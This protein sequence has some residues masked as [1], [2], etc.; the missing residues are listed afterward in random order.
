MAGI[1]AIAV[2]SV[3]AIVQAVALEWHLGGVAL[4]GSGAIV[5]TA[6]LLY[7]VVMRRLKGHLLQAHE[8]KGQR[9]RDD[10]TGAPNRLL[11]DEHVRRSI[12]RA[13]RLQGSFALH[14]I[15]VDR[16]KSVNS[17]YG[18]AAG[19]AAL[20]E[21]TQR[22]G[23]VLRSHDIVARLSGDKF[24]VVQDDVEH[25][26]DIATLSARLLQSWNEPIPLPSG[27]AIP[28]EC[29]VGTAVYPR[30]GLN[31]GELLTVA[32]GAMYRLKRGKRQP[33]GD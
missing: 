1:V 20:Y 18:Y 22:V 15:D 11:L 2:I 26:D 3:A 10:L 4:A 16:F 17:R 29:S 27:V 30:D 23:A 19:D 33:A 28:I 12:A 7:F 8:Q 13:Q 5:V 14:I 25:D 9:L 24:V 21:L 31:G 32:T 6:I